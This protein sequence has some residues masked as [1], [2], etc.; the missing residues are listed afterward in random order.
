MERGEA[1]RAVAATSSWIIFARDKERTESHREFSLRDEKKKERLWGLSARLCI[2]F[3]RACG[4]AIAHRSRLVTSFVTPRRK[5]AGLHS[6]GLALS[7]AV[8]VGQSIR[9]ISEKEGGMSM[10]ERLPGAS[11]YSNG[12]NERYRR[13]QRQ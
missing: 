6:A 4:F 9:L 1:K 12:N 8:S 13:R 2:I 7:S 5:F 11:E 10:M 3:A